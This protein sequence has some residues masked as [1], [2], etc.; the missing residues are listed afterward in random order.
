[1]F[2]SPLTKS[3]AEKF[4]GHIMQAF[5]AVLE[6]PV[7]IEI[8]C[9]TKRDSRPRSSLALV[10]QDHNVNGS[11]RSEIVEVIESN[12]RRHQQQ[13]QEEERTER[14]GSSGLTRA[15]SKH[16]EASQRI[17]RGKVSLAHMIQQA[18]G[19]TLQNS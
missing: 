17:V 12:G 1:M 6:S 13:K 9:E 3:T 16:M 10:G 5:E 2:S 8:R 11:G 4:R 18:D 14:V 7:T 19:C 15:R